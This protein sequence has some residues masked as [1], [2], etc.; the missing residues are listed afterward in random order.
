M[1][2]DK[3]DVQRSM[4]RLMEGIGLM[5]YKDRLKELQLTTLLERRTRGDLIETYKII[6]GIANYGQSIFRD[7][8]SRSGLNVLKDGKSDQFLPN[9]VANYWNKVPAYVKD[10]PSV[11]AFNA[12]LQVYKEDSLRKGVT[13]GHFWELSDQLHSKIDDSSRDSYVQFMSDHPRIA[14]LRKININ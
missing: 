1:S 8:M 13:Q 10:A 5:T 6:S 11:D 2:S 3:E 7:R 4:T 14:K 9:R 12:R